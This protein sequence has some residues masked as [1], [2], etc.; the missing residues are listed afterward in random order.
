VVQLHGDEHTPAA[1]AAFGLLHRLT[2]GHFHTYRSQDLVRGRTWFMVPVLDNGSPFYRNKK[3]TDRVSR[4][5]SVELLAGTV[6]G[7]RAPV[8]H[9]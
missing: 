5:V 1:L 9:A 7:W 2:G 3:G 4:M 8:L 6:S